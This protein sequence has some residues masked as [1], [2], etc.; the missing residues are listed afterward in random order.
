MDDNFIETEASARARGF[1][2]LREAA[3]ISGYHIDSIERRLRT[4]E[5]YGYK[6]LINGRWRWLVS[7]R[8]LLAYSNPATVYESS[9]PGPKL[10]LVKRDPDDDDQQ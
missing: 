1:I 10:Y 4:G 3:R 2:K 9:R 5:I 7:K 8:S 6:A